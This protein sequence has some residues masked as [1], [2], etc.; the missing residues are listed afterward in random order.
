MA[1]ADA[2]SQ[3]FKLMVLGYSVIPVR[4]VPDDSKQGKFRK[5]PV[6]PW[7]PYQEHAADADTLA[8][9]QRKYEPTHWGVVTGDVSGCFVLDADT[10]EAKTLLAT[11]LGPPHV[12]TPRGGGHWYVA[13]KG[14]AR[15]ATG[16]LPGIDVRGDGGFAT[17]IGPGYAMQ[18]VPIPDELVPYD[19]LPQVLR[20]AL[21]GH[22]KRSAA[23]VGDVIEEGQRNDS[24]ARLA[25]KMRR[26]DASRYEIETALLTFNATRC[27]PPLPDD[28]VRDIARSVARYPCNVATSESACIYERDTS[29]ADTKRDKDV[30]DSVTEAGQRDDSLARSIREWVENMGGGWWTTRDLDAEVG[31]VSQQEKDN[32]RQ[33]IHRLLD[34]GVIQQHAR[35]AK[36]YR[37]VNRAVTHLNF[38]AARPGEVLELHWPL[39]IERL[40]NLYPGNIAVVAGAPN[41]GKTALLLDFIRLN[42]DRF[43]IH[44]FCSEMEA[45]ELRDRLELFPGMSAEDWHF[46]AVQ[47]ATDF[48]QVIVPDCINVVDYLEMTEDL[49]LVNAHL[50]AIQHVLG[51]GLAVVAIQK[52]KG[53]L[54]GRGQEF[55]LEKPRLYL[56]MDAGKLTVVKGKSWARK[57]C[58]PNG[59]S[60]KFAIADGCR[61]ETGDTWKRQ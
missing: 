11:Q 38:K 5:V 24:L 23:G 8:E 19:A 30:T 47:R 27:R 4:L 39:G 60:I 7:T 32:R 18:R 1:D 55:S 49:Y 2:Y 6:V 17:I 25:G 43:P 20:D 36:Q 46:D 44:Y 10:D 26:V 50:T 41:A 3:A 45:P 15:T 40:V 56:S 12:T 33:V 28:E 54:Y 29:S 35:I 16:V 58:D 9:W 53:A 14:C 59:L 22:Q 13:R 48:D 34:E 42:M 37:F 31:I 57:N 61:F 51:S 52:K 21:N